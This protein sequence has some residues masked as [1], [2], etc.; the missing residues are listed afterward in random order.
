MLGNITY[1]NVLSGAMV[2][3]RATPGFVLTL[4]AANAS[5][6]RAPRP[7]YRTATFQ[8]ASKRNCSGEAKP[9]VQFPARVEEDWRNCPLDHS[10]KVKE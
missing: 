3:T 4:W 9:V 7:D 6:V 1:G 8:R 5:S 2:R 10:E